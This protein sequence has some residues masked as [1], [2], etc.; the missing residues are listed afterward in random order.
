M[1]V[2]SVSLFPHVFVAESNPLMHFQV[3][4]LKVDFGKWKDEDESGAED[5]PAAGAAG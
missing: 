1:V 4:W 3:H 5:E 2:V